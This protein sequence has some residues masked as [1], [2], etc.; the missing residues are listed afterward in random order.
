M[1]SSNVKRFF[2]LK[3]EEDSHKEIRLIKEDQRSS[4][5]SED[6]QVSQDKFKAFF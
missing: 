6:N 5:M 1:L 3:G 4:M 2:L